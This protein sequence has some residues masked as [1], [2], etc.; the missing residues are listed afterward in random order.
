MGASRGA[1]FTQNLV[2]VG[3][4][5]ALGGLTGIGFAWL[6]LR[7]VESLY[8]GYQH[9]VNLDPL[10]LTTAVGLSVI[11]A[12]AAGLYPV[13]RVSRLQPAGLLKTQ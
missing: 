2:E 13:W 5:G 11:A 3:T 4:I 12:V 10:L 6:G 7:A 9:L 1:V 8:R